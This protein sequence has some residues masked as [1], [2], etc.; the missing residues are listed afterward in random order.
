MDRIQ[1]LS[2]H[3]IL[4]EIHLSDDEKKFVQGRKYILSAALNSWSWG[5]SIYFLPYFSVTFTVPTKLV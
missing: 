5:E 1:L 4:I 2:D 3:E